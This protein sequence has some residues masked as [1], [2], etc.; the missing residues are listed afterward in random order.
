MQADVGLLP[1]MKQLQALSNRINLR[2]QTSDIPIN[3][4]LEED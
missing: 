3:P 1:W 4:S 2:L